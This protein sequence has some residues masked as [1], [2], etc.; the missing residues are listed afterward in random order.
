MERRTFFGRLLGGAAA[1]AATPA[2]GFTPRPRPTRLEAGRLI[3]EHQSLGIPP[4]AFAVPGGKL[5]TRSVTLDGD[6]LIYLDEAVACPDGRLLPPAEASAAF[7]L[8]DLSWE[9]E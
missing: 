9:D 8:P 5:P 4:C 7:C 1:L 3:L 2:G 6:R